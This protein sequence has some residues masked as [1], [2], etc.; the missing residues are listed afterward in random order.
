MVFVVLTQHLL[1][2][3]YV[4][5][6]TVST[7]STEMDGFKALEIP[8]AWNLTVINIYSIDG[9][10]EKLWVLAFHDFF[11]IAIPLNTK[12]VLGKERVT[13]PSLSTIFC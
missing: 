5:V 3:Y 9:M 4:C 8:K 11:R 12:K 2:M 6:I 10:V 7:V 1:Q 13:C